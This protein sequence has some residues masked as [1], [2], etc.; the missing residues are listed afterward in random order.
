MRGECSEGKFRT[1]AMTEENGWETGKREQKRGWRNPAWV[2]SIQLHG[3]A[4]E[5]S[6]A[7]EV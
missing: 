1:V 6:C 7:C 4:A 5:L 3:H 2:A